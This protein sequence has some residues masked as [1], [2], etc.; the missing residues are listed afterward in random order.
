MSQT[1][2][3]VARRALVLIGALSAV[4]AL[5]MSMASSAFAGSEVFGGTVPAKSVVYSP[6]VGTLFAINAERYS[7]AG[8]VCTGPA[9]FPGPSYP[10]GFECGVSFGWSFANIT[11]H[12]ALDNPNS[13]AVGASATAFFR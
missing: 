5:A 11:A 10:D 8:S 3:K 2:P 9:V 1:S 13:K 4:M 12:A 7:G 6:S